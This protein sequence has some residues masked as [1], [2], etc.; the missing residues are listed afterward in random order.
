[1]VVE[2]AASGLLILTL[3]TLRR[4]SEELEKD[5]RRKVLV[6]VEIIVYVELDPKLIVIIVLS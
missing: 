3:V 2:I 4:L 5:L 6:E 1:M